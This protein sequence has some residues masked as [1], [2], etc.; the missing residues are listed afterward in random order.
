MVKRVTRRT[1]PLRRRRTQRRRVAVMRRT[2]QAALKETHTFSNLNTGTAYYDYQVS[3]ARFAR[4]SNVAKGYREF[5]ITKVTYIYKP[6]VDTFPVG[7]GGVPHLYFMIDK[8]GSMRDFNTVEELRR[9]GAK[10][11]RFDDKLITTSFKPAVLSYVRDE[12]NLTNQ[13][14]K[15]VIS[16]WMSCD[17][18]NADVTPQSWAANSIDHL[19]IAWMVDAYATPIAYQVEMVAHF[20]FRKPSYL[21]TITDG[22]GATQAPSINDD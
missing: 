20:E 8:T 12:N 15:P 1:R 6:I 18:F 10:P 22:L 11:R 16:P 2:E 19:G 14:S 21:R 9:A 17:K 3:L 5:R 13:W 4:A 7:G